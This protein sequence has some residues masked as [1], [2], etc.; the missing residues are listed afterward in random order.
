M[1]ELDTLRT[2]YRFNAT[3]RRNYLDAILALPPPERLKDRGA[4]YPSLQ[5]IYAHVL[6]SLRFWFD[7]VPHDRAAEAIH[8]ELPAREMT[9]E[10]L[11]RA[12][13]VVEGI[14]TEFL[15][16]LGGADLA[17]EI[18]CHFPD[19]NGTPGPAERILIGDILWHVVEEEFQHRGELNA[20][21][22]QM[23]VDPPLGT[24]GLWT[25]LKGPEMYRP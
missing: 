13:E 1:S 17:R 18:E 6:D 16:T 5:E 7:L 23:N 25:Q 12:T 3:V 19:A 9:E 24:F 22:W 15:G 14:V 10:Q 4:S 8:L 21:L 2:F 20:L 11:R